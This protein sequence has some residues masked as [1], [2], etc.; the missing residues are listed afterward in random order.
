MLP[1]EAA[2]RDSACNLSL[3]AQIHFIW[4]NWKAFSNKSSIAPL[5]QHVCDQTDVTYTHFPVLLIHIFKDIHTFFY[6]GTSNFGAEAERSYLL[7]F[8]AENVLK[9]RT[10]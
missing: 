1:S 3:T 10:L 6:I 5:F 4:R 7:R 8:E 9:T 2:F